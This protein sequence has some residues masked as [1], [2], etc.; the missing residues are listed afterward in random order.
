[1]LR[2]KRPH[3]RPGRWEPF[4]DDYKPLSCPEPSLLTDEQWEVVDALYIEMDVGADNYLIDRE[5]RAEMLR[6]F[7]ARTGVHLPELIFAAAIIARRKSGF[8]PKTGGGA[9]DTGISFGDIGQV[10]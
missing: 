3:G 8:L 5:L 4:G 9:S 6:R 7:I 10:A 1:M 2:R